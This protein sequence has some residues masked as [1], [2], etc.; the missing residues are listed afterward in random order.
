MTIIWRN[1]EI[2]GIK[3]RERGYSL[4]NTDQDQ[5][6]DKSKN[7]SLLQKDISA[8]VV[9]IGGGMAGML[10]AYH[11]Q[12]KGLDVVVL[13][14][15][16]V[17]SGKTERT[18]AKI[19][20]QHGL[21]YDKLM[22]YKGYDFAKAYGESNR[23]AVESYEKIINEN[24]I[25]C[26]FE[27][28]SN[29]IYTLNRIDKL[30]N[31]KKA[32]EQI[33]I[34]TTITKETGLP[35]SIQGA[36]RLDNQAQFHPLK[37]LDGLRNHVKVY[38][39]VQITEIHQEGYV[40]AKEGSVK[41]K[42]IVIATHYPFINVPGFHFLKQHQE[43]VYLSAFKGGPDINGMY[44]DENSS[45][46]TLRNYQDL[47]ILGSGSHRTGKRNPVDAYSKIEG[48]AKE[49]F[50]EGKLA[51]LW[52]NQDCMTLDQVP[53]IGRYSAKYPNIYL[54]TGFNKW[55]M[56]SSMVAAK[57]I[58]DSIV[59]E[60]NP[61]QNTFNPFRSK[62]S[63]SVNLLGDV[64]V[65]IASQY[66][67]RFKLTTD[68]IKGIEAG[69]AGI[70]MKSG[71]R[72]GVYRDQKD[73]YYFISTKCPHLGCGLEW[74]PNELTWDCPCHGSRFDYKGKLIDNPSTRDVFDAEQKRKK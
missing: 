1:S 68:D 36:L 60:N 7:D 57:I 53:Y 23:A 62:V 18:T 27:R 30:Q 70:I 24:S 14:K 22:K 19:T 43:R 54:A 13:E 15:Y 3:G 44:I 42:Y 71:Q 46:F 11:L 33:G 59:K 51:Y 55:G 29:Y 50:P 17:G 40:A 35:F 69:K 41:A 20:L 39:H 34:E 65:T 25:H 16:T 58:T 56:T 10:T 26:D 63:G 48:F 72:V 8:D 61:Y 2:N 73:Q 31:E 47:L 32:M 64:G 38:E 45:G 28:K 6:K 4:W 49:W 52:S 66:K 12:Q 9:V 37:F 74:N 21:I 67:E 5:E